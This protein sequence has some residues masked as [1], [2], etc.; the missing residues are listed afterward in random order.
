MILGYIQVVKCKNCGS[1]YP[2]KADKY[3]YEIYI[4]KR[5]NEHRCETCGAITHPDE[6]E[7][8]YWFCSREC[9]MEF[10]EKHKDEKFKYDWEK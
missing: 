10:L 6:K 3:H 2:K 9:L 8:N 1:A 5:G 4:K 7:F